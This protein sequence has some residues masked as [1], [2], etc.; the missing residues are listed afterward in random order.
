MTQATANIDSSASQ[1]DIHVICIQWGTAY[2]A[3]DINRLYSMVARNTTLPLKFHLFSN[4]SLPALNPEILQHPEP[5]VELP[6]AKGNLN[7]RKTVGLC[8]PDIA[9][10]QGKRVFFF[11]LDV[12]ITNNLDALFTYPQDDQFYIINDWNTKGDHVG[13]ATCYSFIVG[14]LSYIKEDFES[15]QQAVIARYGTATQQYL[16]AKV[17]ERFGAMQFW[18]D[19]W[20]RSFKYHCL[21]PLFVRR[22]VTPKKPPEETMVLAFH[23]NPNIQ[24]AIVGVWQS[25]GS[26]KQESAWKRFYKKF[27]AA[28]WIA[29]YWK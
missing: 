28:E 11:D 8:T 21:A 15:N 27:R 18:P 14:S 10:L 26:A 16:S 19:A 6:Q 2:P 23:G 25:P 29:D 13:Q 20:F 3:E 22:F 12:V 17:I 1:E 5:G 4:E 24:D 9:G 7:Y